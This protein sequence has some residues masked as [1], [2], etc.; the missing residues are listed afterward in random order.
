[1]GG[2]GCYAMLADSWRRQIRSQTLYPTELW[3]RMSEIAELAGFSGLRN[4]PVQRRCKGNGASNPSPPPPEAGALGGDG[5]GVGELFAEP[6]DVPEIVGAEDVR[7]L[8][9]GDLHRV[10]FL[11]AARP[12]HG[13][14]R[15]SRVV[16][17][18]AAG[19]PANGEVRRRACRRPDLAEVAE[20]PVLL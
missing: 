17:D 7:C 13:H 4:P 20:A 10:S 3:A 2:C 18:V 6:L 11:H 8:V 19:D 5:A 14:R 12:K 9:A 15:A 1:M 16:E